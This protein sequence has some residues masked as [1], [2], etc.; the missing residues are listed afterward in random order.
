MDKY[1]MRL[2]GFGLLFLL[3]AFFMQCCTEHVDSKMQSDHLEMLHEK[4]DYIW[5]SEL[6]EYVNSEENNIGMGSC[7][8]RK[9][10]F[11]NWVWYDEL[12]KEFSNDSFWY[13]IVDWGRIILYVIGSALVLMSKLCSN[14]CLRY[15]LNKRRRRTE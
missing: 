12:E 2:E 7:L 11:D 5:Y 15:V 6:D 3:L 10:V 4:L 1:R 13:N 8:N 14:N 9:L